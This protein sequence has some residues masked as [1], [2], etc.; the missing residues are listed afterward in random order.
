MTHPTPRLKLYTS[1]FGP[2]APTYQRLLP[3]PDLQHRSSSRLIGHDTLLYSAQVDP[4]RGLDLLH[5]TL[6]LEIREDIP[7]GMVGFVS[8]VRLNYAGI[9]TEMSYDN[10]A[11]SVRARFRELVENGDFEDTS[12]LTGWIIAGATI[13][14]TTVAHGAQS[15]RINRTSPDRKSV[16]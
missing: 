5:N 2:L 4:L 14:T 13:N 15:C 12:A 9:V 1:R 3:E 11:T 7:G 8:A 16:V 6:G 10:L